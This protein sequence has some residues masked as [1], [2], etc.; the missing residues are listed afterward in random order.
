V[1]LWFETHATS[2]DNERGLA[3]GHF[4]VDLSG[5]GLRQ[6]AALAD[7]YSDR[8]LSA[9]HTSDLKRAVATAEIAFARRPLP[10][11][12]D[13]RLRECN[14]GTW[15]RCRAQDMEA[16]R[17]KF[18]DQ[19]FPDGESFRDV[20]RRVEAFLND[21]TRGEEQVLVI[22]HRAT[23]YA[24][25]HLL[26]GRDLSEVINARWTWRSGWEYRL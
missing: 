10:C 14:Y 15:S 1:K 2:L 21:L 4:D 17:T 16:A 25:E 3:S 11:F 5:T 22:G 8:A 7:R 26:Q 24:L 12:Q 6:A 20:V 18:I 23:W 19:P 13:A 9:V